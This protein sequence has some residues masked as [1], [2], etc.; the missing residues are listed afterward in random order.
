MNLI[1]K[2]KK[3]KDNINIRYKDLLKELIYYIK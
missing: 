3:E 1:F 2:P